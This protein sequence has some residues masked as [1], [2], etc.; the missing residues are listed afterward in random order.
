MIA[1]AL[2]TNGASKVY[3]MGRRKDKLEDTAES[4]PQRNIIPLVCDVTSKESLTAAAAQI[5]SEVGY[6]NL[7][8]C[9]S[10]VA[11]PS[12]GH[13]LSP[14]PSI[15]DLQAQV[16]ATPPEEFTKAFEVNVTGVYYTAF[17]FLD[18][19]AAGNERKN[20]GGGKVKSQILITSSI[21]AFNRSLGTGFAYNTSKA[22]VTHLT[23]MLA[24]YFVP[25][26]IRVN[27]LAPGLFPSEISAVMLGS[28]INKG[29]GE[30]DRG[31]LPAERLGDEQDMGGTVLYL[32]SRAGAYVNGCV[33][34]VDGGR[35]CLLPGSY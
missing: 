21:A 26:H 15:A 18:L 5:R 34:V 2:S 30:W 31:F 3:I 8:I 7:L 29:E 19:L 28:N 32:V 16:L 20:Y 9:N 24:N 14:N 13:N 25:Y 1:K 17:A 12:H 23:K 27:A 33:L 4:A 22:A 10:G 11:G 35:L 6:I